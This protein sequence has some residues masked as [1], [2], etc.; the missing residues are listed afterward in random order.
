MGHPRFRAAMDAFKFSVKNKKE[1]EIAGVRDFNL[2]NLELL[3]LIDHCNSLKTCK[4]IYA[5]KDAKTYQKIEEAYNSLTDEQKLTA[6]N[7]QRAKVEDYTDILIAEM[8]PTLKFAL[9]PESPFKHIVGI[10][11][12]ELVDG[13]SKKWKEKFRQNYSHVVMEDE[14]VLMKQQE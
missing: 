2:K 11:E 8:K 13:V 3:Y 12:P 7:A 10:I 14:E 5:R 9:T 6:P 1:N 4:V